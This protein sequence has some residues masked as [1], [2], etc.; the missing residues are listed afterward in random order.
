MNNFR[1]IS[2]YTDKYYE[3]LSNFEE[4]LK[5]YNLCYF[6]SYPGDWDWD[7]ACNYKPGFILACLNMFKCPVVWIDIDAVVHSNLSYFDKLI[8]NNVDFS[9][10]FRDNKELLS[11]TLF[12]NYT[13]KAK[14]LLVLWKEES[15]KIKI[16][17]QRN[18]Q[19]ALRRI[20]DIKIEYLPITYCYFDLLKNRLKENDKIEIE[21]F[22]ASRRFNP[23]H[24]IYGKRR[25]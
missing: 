3:Y 17:D 4:S 10:Y 24:P 22:Q 16:W 2:F 25:I 7:M 6:I 23:N 9:F 15:K 20:K 5:K 19:N 18:L 8:D 11:G 14:E 21:H 13:E 12:F 1:V